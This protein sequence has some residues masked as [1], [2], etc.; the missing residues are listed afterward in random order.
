VKVA[1][2]IDTQQIIAEVATKHGFAVKQDDP[3]IV[4]ATVNAIVFEQI[5]QRAGEDISARISDFR[6]TID[7]LER[8]AGEA[9][10]EQT[11]KLVREL[12]EQLTEEIRNRPHKPK[13]CPNS[14]NN[15]WLF[16]GISMV[17]FVL[18]FVA[19]KFNG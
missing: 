6:Q 17:T 15:L 12:R 11:A 8:R 13:S 5:M 10:G 7:N 18:G 16:I 19:A 9:L 14:Y 2:E 1:V 4:L 3:I